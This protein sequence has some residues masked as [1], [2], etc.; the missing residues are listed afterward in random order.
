MESQWRRQFREFDPRD[1]DVTMRD[2]SAWVGRNRWAIALYGRKHGNY[3]YLTQSPS[4]AAVEVSR[5]LGQY[6]PS[7]ETEVLV[8]M[9]GR[10]VYRDFLINPLQVAGDLRVGKDNC[11]DFIDLTRRVIDLHH[12]RDSMVG[13][14]RFC[15]ELVFAIASH[16]P[17]TV[18][19]LFYE[20]V[21]KNYPTLVMV[22]DCNR[23]TLLK[24]H[25]CLAL[26]QCPAPDNA[27]DLCY[28]CRW[29]MDLVERLNPLLEEDARI[30]ATHPDD[31]ETPV[32]PGWDDNWEHRPGNRI[33]EM[34]KNEGAMAEANAQDRIEGSA[35]KTSR[36]RKP[37]VPS[38]DV[39]RLDEQMGTIPLFL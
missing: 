29:I 6:L 25:K 8:A 15:Y 37:E 3:I 16:M 33:G 24:E 35:E 10:K 4:K 22:V 39:K 19:K 31:D 2:Y 34:E 11:R 17:K 18:R 26:G 23:A 20:A 12:C 7:V 14:E 5:D 28:F 13:P 32:T 27:Q 1:E 38:P 36:V 30:N 21:R 9:I